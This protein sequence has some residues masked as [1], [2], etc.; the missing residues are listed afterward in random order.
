MITNIKSQEDIEKII[1]NMIDFQQK[2][3]KTNL[4]MKEELEK[5]EVK[6]V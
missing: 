4:E 2:I 6:N 5:N 3:N 1:E